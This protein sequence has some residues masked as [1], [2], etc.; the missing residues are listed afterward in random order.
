MVKNI[1][2]NII[3]LMFLLIPVILVSCNQSTESK[4]SNDRD[5]ITPLAGLRHGILQSP[6]NILSKKTIHGKHKVLLHFNDEI[7]KIENL[8]H[9]VQLDFAPGSTIEKDGKVY[10]FEQIHFHTPSEHHIDGITYPMEMHVVNTIHK[11]EKAE[12]TQYL[13]LAI[14][15][16]MGDANAFIQEFLDLI[17]KE[18]E[19]KKEVPTGIIRMSDLMETAPENELRECYHYSGSLTTPPYTQSVNWFISKHIYEASEDQIQKIRRIEGNNA[20]H[21][22]ARYGRVVVDNE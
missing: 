10:E 8:G 19:S 7:N 16:K 15:F 4:D 9:T 14:L 1:R 11:N 2:L 3:P 21:I 5:S 17:P 20:R 12:E 18:P 22:Q 13:V 6:I